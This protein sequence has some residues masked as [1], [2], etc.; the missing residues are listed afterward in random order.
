MKVYSLHSTC[1]SSTGVS[2]Y[3]FRFVGRKVAL[4]LKTPS[5]NGSCFNASPHTKILKLSLN[6]NSYLFPTLPRVDFSSYMFADFMD[7]LKTVY[8]R[9][10]IN[11]ILFMINRLS[12]STKLT[13][14]YSIFQPIFCLIELK[15]GA[16]ERY[17]SCL[18]IMLVITWL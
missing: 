15:L 2:L 3:R 11:F 5:S 17:W 8:T 14:F 6:R 12:L 10:K 16:L 1:I 18:A 13:E 9:L 4:L 7:S